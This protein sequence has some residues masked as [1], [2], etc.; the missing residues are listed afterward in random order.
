M[1]L[2]HYQILC[3]EIAVPLG[4]PYL[5]LKTSYTT[6]RFHELQEATSGF[7]DCMINLMEL[8]LT[9]WL[10]I[11]SAA[12]AALPLILQAIK[13]QKYDC[14]PNAFADA[15][16][17]GSVKRARFDALLDAMQIFTVQYDEAE[18]ISAITRQAIQHAQG[19]HDGI[20]SSEGECVKAPSTS[21]AIYLQSAVAVDWSLS[22]GI[23]AFHANLPANLREW[24]HGDA[25]SSR[26]QC[27]FNANKASP[28]FTDFTEGN[29]EV[30]LRT[31]FADSACF[32]ASSGT[33]NAEE[34][35]NGTTSSM[36]PDVLFN[37]M[38]LLEVPLDQGD[39]GSTIQTVGTVPASILEMVNVSTADFLMWGSEMDRI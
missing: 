9:R 28:D 39:A 34:G 1:C 2:R 22:R 18:W 7:T 32:S 24:F 20:K 15:Y 23:Y 14:D 12:F 17:E 30:Y 10:P 38:D 5:Y 19:L 21:R 16:R 33:S 3:T 4:L 26:S 36:G 13:C 6:Q 11:S 29:A 37:V 35:G 27:D 31:Q 25:E 8:Q